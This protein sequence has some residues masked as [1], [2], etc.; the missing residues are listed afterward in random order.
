MSNEPEPAA[1]GKAD[2]QGKTDATSAYGLCQPR[3]PP[4]GMGPD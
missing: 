3:R 4:R 2:K 1:A